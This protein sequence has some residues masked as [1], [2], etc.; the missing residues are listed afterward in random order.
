MSK[1]ILVIDDDDQVRTLLV[2]MLEFE[3]YAVLEAPDGKVGYK[4]YLE[5]NPDLVITD[6]IMPEREGIETIRELRK[7]NP[8]IKIIAISGGGSVEP[9]QYLSMAKRLGVKRTF[10]KPF[11]REEILG[12]VKELI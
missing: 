2:K 3:G 12:A 8:E 7:D 10:S 5:N 1:T 6:L 11:K 9:E 4:L